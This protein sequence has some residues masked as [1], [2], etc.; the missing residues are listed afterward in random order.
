MFAD[1]MYYN[2]YNQTVS[3]RQLWQA[4]S[5]AAV[6]NSFIATLIPASFLLFV[7]IPFAA[8]MHQK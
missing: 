6:P 4:K 1:T 8:C 2:Y 5:V 3:I 7:D